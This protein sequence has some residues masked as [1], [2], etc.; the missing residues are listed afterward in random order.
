MYPAGSPESRS[1]VLDINKL[2]KPPAWI[3]KYYPV[4]NTPLDRAL[5]ILG[6][7]GQ[8][9]WEADLVEDGD[10]RDP[11]AAKY[12]DAVPTF[13]GLSADGE[14]QGQ[15]GYVNYGRKEDY[16]AIIASGGDLEGKIVL[17]RYGAVFRGLKVRTVM[18]PYS[19]NLASQ[20][21]LCRSRARK[22]SV[23]LA[24]SSTPILA[25]TAQSQSPTATRRTPRAPHAT[26]RRCSAVAYSSSRCTPATRPLPVSL[27]TRTP[28]ARR[29]R[30]SR[31]F[32]ACLSRGR[33][34]RSC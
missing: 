8:P 33:M 30:T 29:A 28:R 22:N 4:M 12:R 19:F 20:P 16:D 1:A 10:P 14:V 32:R 27:P 13:H 11:E 18:L 3:D 25:T 26:R 34:R 2:R 6:D 7:D 5:S 17:A 23:L 21:A 15:L 31:R 24:C 9:E